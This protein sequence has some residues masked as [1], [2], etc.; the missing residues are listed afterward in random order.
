MDK[1]IDVASYLRPAVLPKIK[2]EVVAIGPVR[3][4]FVPPVPQ[5]WIIAANKIATKRHSPAA[6]F[7]GLILW[8]RLR[9]RK[10]QPLRIT[11]AVWSEFE[12]SR[13]AVRRALKALED[14]GLI[15]VKRFKHRSP[16][17][18]IMMGDLS[19]ANL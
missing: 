1:N 12:L 16:E 15:T 17:I 11:K 3:E 10:Q 5:R 7:V 13:V 4:K 6:L 2:N 19:R 9:I 18:T 14:G 8:Q